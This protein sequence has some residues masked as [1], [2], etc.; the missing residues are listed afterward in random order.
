M[1]GTAAEEIAVVGTAA[2]GTVVV[3]FA[4][5]DTA[6]GTGSGRSEVAHTMFAAGRRE[7]TGSNNNPSRCRA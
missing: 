5:P 2:A 4:M 1:A 6:A 7:D 3:G